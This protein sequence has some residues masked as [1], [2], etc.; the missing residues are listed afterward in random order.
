MNFVLIFRQWIKLTHLPYQELE[1]IQDNNFWIQGYFLL[2]PLP[3]LSE[4]L[5]APQMKYGLPA[6]IEFCRAS[7]KGWGQRI[8]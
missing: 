6:C 4:M 1:E 8:R 2:Y 3:Q 5:L 7:E